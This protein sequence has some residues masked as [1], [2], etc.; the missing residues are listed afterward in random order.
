MTA[1][2]S[3]SVA[4][5]LSSRKKVSSSFAVTQLGS[6]TKETSVSS[7]AVNH[8]GSL[9][10][11]VELEDLLLCISL[12]GISESRCPS[13]SGGMGI[14]LSKSVPSITAISSLFA[15]E[16]SWLASSMSAL[17]CSPATSTLEDGATPCMSAMACSPASSPSNGTG[18]LASS[19]LSI[20]ESA[21][22]CTAAW[23][24]ISASTCSSFTPSPSMGIA[25]S[26]FP[27]PLTVPSEAVPSNTTTS[28]SSGDGGKLNSSKNLTVGM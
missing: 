7:W 15:E 22:S 3:F 5:S 16:L 6:V 13:S 14:L 19:S 12:P 1:D 23:S 2:T 11:P 27:S 8:S 10:S 26:A 17:T 24:C 28:F 18:V 20:S 21:P 4:A 25:M 9:I